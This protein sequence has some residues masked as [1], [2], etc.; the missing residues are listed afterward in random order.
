MDRVFSMHD[1]E[2][3]YVIP[4]LLRGAGLDTAV[5]DIL[6]L[7]D[8]I[9]ETSE[10]SRRTVPVQATS[11]V[12]SASAIPTPIGLCNEPGRRPHARPR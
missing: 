11:P 8:R 3:V 10:R 12:A 7:T 1:Q 4:E 9:D 2:S 5:A 6:H